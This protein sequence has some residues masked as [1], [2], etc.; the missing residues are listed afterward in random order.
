MAGLVGGAQRTLRAGATRSQALRARLG[1][2]LLRGC[3]LQ[4]HRARNALSVHQLLHSDLRVH[5]RGYMCGYM[6]GGCHF[7]CGSR[8]VLHLCLA[9]T[10][11]FIMEPMQLQLS[12]ERDKVYIGMYAMRSKLRHKR[13]LHSAQLCYDVQGIPQNDGG[14]TRTS[15]APELEGTSSARSAERGR[16]AWPSTKKKCASASDG[17]DSAAVVLPSR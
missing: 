9:C 3:A 17:T 13:V 16:R 2:R 15:G 7:G 11:S 8:Q 10:G 6:R 12:Q 14:S 4:A 1:G 5:A